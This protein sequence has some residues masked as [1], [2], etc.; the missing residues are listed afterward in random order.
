[1]TKK[2]AQRPAPPAARLT[3]RV[4]VVGHRPNRLPRDKA[5]L[6]AIRTRIEAV[7]DA[8]TDAVAAF[9]T[10]PDASLYAPG[11]SILRAVSPLAEGSD[12]LF[13]E[14]ALD[15]GYEL[16]V[17]MPFPRQEYEKDFGDA[18]AGSRAMFGALLARAEANHLTIVELDGTREHQ[19]AAYSAAGRLVLNQSDLLV[20][21][22][23]GKA[24][25]GG[26]GTVDTL[27]VALDFH[28]P[29]LWID[30]EQ[31]YG[32]AML[33]HPSELTPAA[34]KE[35]LAPAPADAA[36]DL[37]RAALKKVIDEIVLT[38]LALP[39]ALRKE[40]SGHHGDEVEDPKILARS[41]F[42]ERKPRLNAYFLWKMFRDV[43][44]DGRLHRPHLAVPDFVGDIAEDWPI[45]T[46]PGATEEAAVGL[47]VNRRLRVHY[48]WADKLAGYYADAHRTSFLLISFLSFFA[49]FFALV[50]VALKLEDIQAADL[51]LIAAEG[52]V[53]V[54]LLVVVRVANA[55]RW[56]Q[57]WLEYRMLAEWMRQLRFLIPLG[58]G[59]PL[60]R[61]PAHLAVYGDPVRSWMYWQVR[62]VARETGLPST[63]GTTNYAAECLSYLAEIVGDD[64]RGQ[65]CF[66]RATMNRCGRIHHRLHRWTGALV[67]LTIIGVAA[68]F[69]MKLLWRKF[70]PCDDTVIGW[71]T[72]ALLLMSAGFP[73]LGAA[74]ANINNQGEFARLAK[75]ARAMTHSFERFHHE[76]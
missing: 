2:R 72:G 53:L 25:R 69:A 19:A 44:G 28:V 66:H 5:G 45:D 34:D 23:D 9:G 48:A 71:L 36:P 74:L 4:G 68:H 26:G 22:W 59:R 32:W 76:A 58:G 60:P 39:V 11:Q 61:T 20:V 56:H 57:R 13:A 55:R 3:F 37:D 42:A 46:P 49:V 54:A 12:R 50:P 75:R 21:V 47:W 64:E 27:A 16:C 67:I 51:S 73:A 24:A 6:A 17:P 43:V 7:L 63:P 40:G 31:P 18:D 41:Y 30:A 14:A 33:R 35:R 29:V 52:F 38:E 15:R 65:L 70:F 10:K 1:M 62:A 8:V